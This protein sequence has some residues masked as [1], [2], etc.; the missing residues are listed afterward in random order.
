[1]TTNSAATELTST[2]APQAATPGRGGEERLDVLTGDRCCAG[3]GFN[4]AG[5]TIVREA[6]YGLLM[7]RCPECGVV[8]ALQEYPALSRV[9]GRLRMLVAA[10]WALILVGGMAA[11]GAIV[12]GFAW[13]TAEMVVS[14]YTRAIHTSWDKA[15]AAMPEP[16]PSGY[17]EQQRLSAEW[18]KG[19]P[20]SSFLAE[21]GGWA[22][23]NW[24][25][26]LSWVLAAA[27]LVPIG[28]V[29]A[30]LLT[31]LRGLKLLLAFVPAVG[32]GG[33]LLATEV[34]SDGGY[35]LSNA[36]WRQVGWL[37]MAMT[38]VFAA[39]SLWVGALLGR[40]VARAAL[41][42]TLPPQLLAAFGYLWRVDGLAQPR[43][44]LRG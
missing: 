15:F 40:R 11:T 27:V 43:I 19:L 44:R 34:M 20:P 25:G 29:W 9:A 35:P 22:S 31:R 39:G 23:L 1:M 36:A 10:I 32:F 37:P 24:L 13:A 17:W 14:P 8:A 7:V 5:Q 6:H 28:M 2:G 3:C 21:H 12:Y 38:L 18:W 16:K 41:A 26:L 30:V 42:M 33:L 4:L